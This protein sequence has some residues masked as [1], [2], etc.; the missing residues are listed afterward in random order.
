MQHGAEADR[1]VVA[2]VGPPDECLGDGGCG[3]CACCGWCG[4]CTCCGCCGSDRGE[5]S[6]NEASVP[7]DSA[8]GRN[9]RLMGTVSARFLRKEKEARRFVVGSAISR[10]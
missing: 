2:G 9:G 8:E 5:W 3:C 1:G 6:G 7:S 10:S 4:C